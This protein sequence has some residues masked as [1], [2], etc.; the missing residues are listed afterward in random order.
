MTQEAV[1][2]IIFR[3]NRKEVLLVKRRDL[4]VWVL[5]GG[6]LDKEENPE[7]GVAR[8]VLEETGFQVKIERQVA[9]Y[10]PVNR[11]TQTTYF[12]ECTITGGV[13]T[14]N[15]EAKEVRFFPV[16]KLPNK[17]APPFAR[18][19]EDAKDELSPTITKKTE[20]VTYTILIKLL[21]TH[22]ILILRYLLT[23]V[24]IRFNNRT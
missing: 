22:P 15:E 7:Q 14:P 18:W 2:G 23:K 3:E 21:I 5:P 24:G 1:Y 17:L 10:L 19:I 8:E 12:F 4:P 6:G 11:L 16:K 9:K 20:G 13:A